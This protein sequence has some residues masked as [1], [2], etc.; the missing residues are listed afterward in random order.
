MVLGEFLE[1][2]GIGFPIYTNTQDSVQIAVAIC[3]AAEAAAEAPSLSP[4]SHIK[5][6]IHSALVQRLESEVRKSG[7]RQEYSGSL[8]AATLSGHPYSY[9]G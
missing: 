7:I 3:N 1:T 2:S 4:G 9:S 5:A 8:T 6:A